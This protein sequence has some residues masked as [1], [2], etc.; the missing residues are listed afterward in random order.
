MDAE[1]GA[2]CGEHCF[3]GGG[4]DRCGGDD[5]QRWQRPMAAGCGL[6]AAGSRRHPADRRSRY[7]RGD[8]PFE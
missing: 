1:Q 5:P 8:L 2:P 4:F 3:G 7:A 6:C